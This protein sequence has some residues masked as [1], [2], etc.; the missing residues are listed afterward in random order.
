MTRKGVKNLAEGGVGGTEAL[1][2]LIN[3]KTYHLLYIYHEPHPE[4]G[5]LYI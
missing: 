1:T 5:H 3:R 2:P 4:P